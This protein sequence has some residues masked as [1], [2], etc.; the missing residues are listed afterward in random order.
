VA[1]DRWRLWLPQLRRRGQLAQLQLVDA[2]FDYVYRALLRG[3]IALNSKYESP[4]TVA[5]VGSL[6]AE[7]TNLAFAE[8]IAGVDQYDE[9][10]G[11]ALPTWVVNKGN[12]LRKGIVDK[13][14]KRAAR[15]RS[16]LDKEDD[17]E[18]PHVE[19]ANA[20]QR[21]GINAEDEA[22][23]DLAAKDLKQKV[24]AVFDGM[25]SQLCEVLV[26]RY[27]TTYPEGGSV[28]NTAKTMGK[29]A[30]AVT[31]QVSRASKEFRR[32]WQEMYG[33]APF[34]D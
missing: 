7:L 12:A 14:I 25:S 1:D 3:A 9:R 26:L 16:R 24:E 27:M 6:V 19:L 33:P 8:A 32:L 17:G 22:M 34:D 15:E 31:S 18:H 28:A 21:L 5:E 4:L 29:S 23:A 11:A 2:Y 13:E 20:L 30:D 10:K